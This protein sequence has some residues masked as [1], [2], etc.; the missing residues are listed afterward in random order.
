M[1][2]DFY[3]RQKAKTKVI[4]RALNPVWDQQLRP[5]DIVDLRIQALRIE[6]FD[7]DLLTDDFLGSC[8]ML[9]N[10]NLIV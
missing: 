7:K 9:I 5:F 2:N 8:S 6:V 3:K 10:V 4:Y 1:T